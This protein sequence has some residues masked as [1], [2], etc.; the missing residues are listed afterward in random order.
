MGKLLETRLPIALNEVDAGLYNR[1][2]R[3]LEINLG[4]FDT[5]ATP[6]YNN[7]QLSQNKF[8]PGD[9]IWNTNKNVL[10]VY[11]GSKWQDISTRT[12]VGLEATGSVGTLSVSTGGTITIDLK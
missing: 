4:R 9:V 1:M 12:E 2:V 7:T 3:I 10:Q 11:T 5:T 6:E 8:N